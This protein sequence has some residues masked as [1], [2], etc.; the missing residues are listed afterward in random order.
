MR[1]TLPRCVPVVL[2]L[3]AAAGAVRGQTISTPND[4]GTFGTIFASDGQTVG[5]SFTAPNAYMIDFSFWVKSPPVI[6]F[7]A[8]VY[9]W[10]DD[11]QMPTGPALF[12]S[13][14]LTVVSDG[15]CELCQLTVP[16]GINLT[17]GGTY[18]AFLSSYGFSAPAEG[19]VIA[20]GDNNYTGGQ[21]YWLNSGD[22][23]TN[24]WNYMSWV[25]DGAGADLQT[26]M[27]FATEAPVTVMP[28]PV[29]A[30][31]FGA[32]LA[33]LAAARRRRKQA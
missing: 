15:V 18:M 21:L 29:T 2:A 6:P 28:E 10:S 24:N 1:T 12:T 20:M 27:N 17:P 25:S 33:A 22:F 8:Y 19:T 11:Y 9:A 23:T 32:G 4:L 3:V 26:A 16:T 13:G 5:Q 14:D 31:L 30:V 7:K